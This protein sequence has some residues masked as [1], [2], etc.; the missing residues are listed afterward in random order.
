MEKKKSAPRSGEEKRGVGRP[1]TGRTQ[2]HFS[3]RCDI[4]NMEYL[5]S[6]PN[7]GGFINSLLREAREREAWPRDCADMPP[8]IDDDEE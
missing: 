1:S 8:E 3:F 2:K 4:E 5:N 7:K 6:K